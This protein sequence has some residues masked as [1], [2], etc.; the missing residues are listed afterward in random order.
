MASPL[1]SM[2]IFKKSELDPASRNAW[3]RPTSLKQVRGRAVD[4]EHETS[5]HQDG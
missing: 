3:A 1:E 2:R 4:F 5:V